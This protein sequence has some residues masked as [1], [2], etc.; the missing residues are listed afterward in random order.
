MRPVRLTVLP[1]GGSALLTL[2]LALSSVPSLRGSDIPFLLLA[3]TPYLAL[4]AL[5]AG[6]PRSRRCAWSL[7]GLAVVLSVAGVGCFAVD[8]WMFHTVAEHRM[9][10]R[11]TVIVVPMLQLATLATFALMALL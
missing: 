11:F 9:V 1:C 5:A 3:V 4:A 2:V 10:Q 8:S 7:F 6:L